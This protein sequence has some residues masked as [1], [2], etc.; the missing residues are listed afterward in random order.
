MKNHAIDS[1]GDATTARTTHRRV[2]SSQIHL[3]HQPTSENVP[4]RI[5]IRGHS[6][7]ANQRF[8]FG[9]SVRIGHKFK[10]QAYHPTFVAK[11][12]TGDLPRN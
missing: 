11:A 9:W 4:V 7:R 3:R 1:D 6:D 2:T 12:K 8:V 5:S 10:E